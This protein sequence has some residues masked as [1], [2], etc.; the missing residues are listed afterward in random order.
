[1]PD[2][3]KGQVNGVSDDGLSMNGL[4]AWLAPGGGCRGQANEAK[5]EKGQE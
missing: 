2:I 1:M 4:A 3:Y 5:N